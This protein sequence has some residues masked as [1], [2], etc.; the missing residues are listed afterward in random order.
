MSI[1]GSLLHI[2]QVGLQTC[3]HVPERLSLPGFSVS[4]H[5][6]ASVRA[7]YRVCKCT[8]H[9]EYAQ[10]SR[11]SWLKELSARGNKSQDTIQVA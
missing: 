10:V 3:P 4:L 11:P 1:G 6:A 5:V 8:P 9:T 2:C 7:L